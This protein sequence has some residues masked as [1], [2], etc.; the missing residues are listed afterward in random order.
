M[1][2]SPQDYN[3]EERKN[4]TWWSSRHDASSDSALSLRRLRKLTLI[5]LLLLLVM[6]GILIP[7][8]LQMDHRI[9]ADPYKVRLDEHHRNGTHV[10]ALRISLPRRGTPDPQEALVGWRILDEDGIQIHQEY[11]LPPS[12][13]E[14][15]EFLFTMNPGVRYNCEVTAGSRIQE[16]HIPEE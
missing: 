14:A 5:D 13:G 7:W 1:S 16:I 12:P 9:D 15:R 2:V 4:A 11:D 6:M 10:L 8:V 3:R